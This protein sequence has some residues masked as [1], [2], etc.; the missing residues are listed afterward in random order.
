VPPDGLFERLAVVEV[1]A[2]KRPA[3]AERLER[4]LPE[5]NLEHAFA[6]LEDDGKRRVG[7]D[8]AG[9]LAHEF[10]LHSRKH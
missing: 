1:A 4:T 7:R 10:S 8:R 3:S 9:R 6:N 2:G 5:Q